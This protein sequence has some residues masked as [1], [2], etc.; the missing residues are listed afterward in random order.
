MKMTV[1]GE[2]GPTIDW[3]CDPPPAYYPRH[4]HESASNKDS[5][6]PMN[7]LKTELEVWKISVSHYY[8]RHYPYIDIILPLHRYNTTLQVDT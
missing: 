5:I 6:L 1:C 3:R 2:Y 7:C 4:L 8:L